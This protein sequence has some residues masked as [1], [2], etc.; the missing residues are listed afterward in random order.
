MRISVS[1]NFQG[2]FLPNHNFKVLTKEIN[3]SML[4]I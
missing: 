4:L 1:E 2:E 3:A